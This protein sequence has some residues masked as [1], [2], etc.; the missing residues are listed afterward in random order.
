MAIAGQNVR[1]RPLTEAD[2]R[3]R[4]EWTADEELA[5][6]MGVNLDD[7]LLLPPSQ[8]LGENR[9]WF[10]GRRQAGAL[11]F[12]IEAEGRYIGDMDVT[13]QPRERKAELTLFI[14]DRSQ[15]GKG[16][17]TEAVGLVLGFLYSEKPVET[18]EVD[19]APGNDR[20]LRFWKKLGFEEFRTDAKGITYL[21]HTSRRLPEQNETIR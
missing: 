17:G 6:L 5:A 8:Q 4:A 11:L 2:L 16:Y 21:Q 12:A 20:A 3:T 15:W 1:L 19:V 18:V 7:E 10:A 9:S 13:I 14:G